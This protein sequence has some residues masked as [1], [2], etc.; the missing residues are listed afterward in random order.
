MVEKEKNWKKKRAVLK[1]INEGKI[2]KKT[3][4]Q[5]IENLV[6]HQKKLRIK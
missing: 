1:K 2:L 5:K 3:Q 6:E 4:Q